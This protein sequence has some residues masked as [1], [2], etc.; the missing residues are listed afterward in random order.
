MTIGHILRKSFLSALRRSRWIKNHSY[1]SAATEQKISYKVDNTLLGYSV[2]EVENIPELN[3][4]A[5]LLKHG[6]T[7]AEHLHLASADTNNLFAQEGWRLEHEDINDRNSPIVLKGVV[8]NEMK[9]VFSDP[10]QYYARHLQNHLFPS[11]AYSHESGGDPLVIPHLTWQGLKHFHSTLYHPSNSR[12][13]TYGNMPLEV[14]LEKISNHVLQNFKK[15]KIESEIPDV[16]TWIKPKEFAQSKTSFFV[17]CVEKAEKDV[18]LVKNLIPSIFKDVVNE[19][20][21]EKQIQ[22]VLHKIELATKHRTANFGLNCALGVNSMWNHN[23][24]PISAFKVNDHVQ[25]FLNQMKDKPHFLQDKIVQYFQENPHK[26]TLIMKPDKNFEAQEQAKEKALL[27][28]KV[29]KLSDT[30]R[31][32][33]YQ[34]GL[35]L[36]EHQKHIDASCLPTLQIDDVKKS[37][38]KTPLQFISLGNGKVPLQICEQPTNEVTYFRALVDASSL[39]EEDLML[40]PLFTS[41][42]TQMGAGNLNYKELDQEIQLKTGR[43]DVSLH[44]SENPSDPLQFRQALLLSSYCLDKNIE[45]MFSLWKDIITNVQLEDSERLTQLI[46]LG[47]AELAQSITYNG[48]RYSMRKASSTLS[49]CSHLREKTS[50]LSQ[51]TFMKQLA[52]MQN[53]EELLGR[54]KKLADVLFNKI[55]IKCSL[56]AM[57]NF[58]ES[59]VNSLDS[60]LHQ[61]PISEALPDYKQTHYEAKNQKTHFVLP[62]SVNYLGQSILTVPYCNP[63]F[64]SL[65]VAAKLMSSKFLHSEIREKGG[66]Y[67]G[68]A[69]IS[70]GG[71]FMFYSYRDPNVT[72]T[73]K[74][75]SSGVEWLLEGSYSEQDITEAKL[76]VFSEVDAP[77]PPGSKGSAVFLEDISDEMKEQMRNNIFS[78]SRKDL[79]NATQKYLKNSDRVGTA[80]IGPENNYTKSEDSSWNIET[81]EL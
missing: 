12:F 27:E 80:L 58:M 50:G 1:S 10:S 43:L 3:L 2:K 78:C 22:S 53:H 59:A 65:K 18:D 61:L 70:K 7:G 66:A 16:A 69:A 20:F 40:L 36:A 44:L 60:F 41:I 57:P 71:H 75:F 81:N 25:W 39:S 6:A 42:V 11:N 34:Q 15:T 46:Q 68:G 8:F 64:A 24:H 51:I 38:E 63:H 52:E 19:G 73:L 21:P 45:S 79:T 33:I 62:F 28:S 13:I 77:I 9:G 32:Q 47:A 76:G 72:K 29:S 30:E 31:Q 17:G 56:N 74:S 5:I 48:H 4:T 54:L 55:P 67:G 37:V 23:G 35:E 14:H 49:H 26:L